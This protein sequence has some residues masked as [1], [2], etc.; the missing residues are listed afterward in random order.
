MTN[1]ALR[2]SAETDARQ[3]VEAEKA[4][5]LLDVDVTEQ[6]KNAITQ[7]GADP[8]M[9]TDWQQVMQNGGDTGDVDAFISKYG[10]TGQN[11]LPSSTLASLDLRQKFGDYGDALASGSL[12]DSGKEQALADLQSAVSVAAA[13]P[14]ANPT[15]YGTIAGNVI[16][17]SNFNT[18][19]QIADSM[20]GSA[21]PFPTLVQGATSIGMP[22]AFISDMTGF[23]VMPIPPL[24]NASGTNPSILIYNPAINAAAV[25]YLL[26]AYKYDMAAGTQQ[27]LNRS[28]TISFDSGKSGQKSYKLSEGVYEWATDESN[29]WDLHKVKS[30]IV[31]DGSRYDGEFHYLLNDEAMVLAP[32]EVTEHSSDKVVDICFDSG[33]G[34]EMRKTLRS[35]RYI[36]GIDP[37]TG[38]IDLFDADKVED[39]EEETQEYHSSTVIAGSTATR[40]QRVEAL[41]N[42]LRNVDHSSEPRIGGPTRKAVSPTG[43]AKPARSVDSL[44]K[45]LQ[46]TS[47]SSGG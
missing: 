34:A 36:I 11:A 47:A 17:M 3:Q 41:L 35:G 21:N 20:Q 25:S 18:M 2:S 46:R 24:P 7:P 19:G 4:K 5:K 16:N 14:G 12:S 23:P 9:L 39:E 8:K 1:L 22:V 32:G 27:K 43:D 15:F 28:Y 29:G 40:T 44:L 37:E 42:Q 13:V 30:A 38:A 45:S 6:I 33:K 26:D 31:I 10:P